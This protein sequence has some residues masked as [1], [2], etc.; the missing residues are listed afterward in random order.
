M[1]ALNRTEQRMLV[2]GQNLHSL[3][4]PRFWQA[5]YEALS[6]KNIELQLLLC[7]PQ[8]DYVTLA[9]QDSVGH[10]FTDDLKESIPC[11]RYWQEIADKDYD[12]GQLKGRLQIRL[13]RR[14]G[15]LSLT[16]T[17]PSLLSGMLEITPVPYSTNSVNR[18]SFL[19]TRSEHQEMFSHYWSTYELIYRTG[20]SRSIRE[21]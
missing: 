13:S 21:I 16:F 12:N 7:D 18:T 3:T 4:Q 9:M 2:I 10:T 17:D 8:M 20:N 14:I 6:S 1:A 5:A 11:F 19:L 15:S